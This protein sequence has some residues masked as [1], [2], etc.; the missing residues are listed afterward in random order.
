MT[1]TTSIDSTL[2][3]KFSDIIDFLIAGGTDEAD[4]IA[5]RAIGILLSTDGPQ[6]GAEP[7]TD[8]F[9]ANMLASTALVS[10]SENIKHYPFVRVSRD[11]FD[12]EQSGSMLGLTADVL[13]SARSL[14][15]RAE[16]L[17]PNPPAGET[18]DQPF[19]PGNGTDLAAGLDELICRIF[20]ETGSLPSAVVFIVI[21]DEAVGAAS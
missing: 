17:M 9:V 13:G 11:A 1:R 2:T 14:I 19:S 8:P 15:E 5:C 21:D 16:A 10:I 6:T 4:Q 20:E 12:F 3:G 18:L 7:D